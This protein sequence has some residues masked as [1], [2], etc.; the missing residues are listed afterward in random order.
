MLDDVI[1]CRSQLNKKKIILSFLAGFVVFSLS[2][3]DITDFISINHATDY[4]IQY[5]VQVQCISTRGAMC[6][7]FS[8]YNIDIV[9]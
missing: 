5:N 4:I 9:F 1:V 7:R 2:Y 3:L 6:Y 8:K